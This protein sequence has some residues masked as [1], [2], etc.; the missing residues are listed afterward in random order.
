MFSPIRSRSARRRGREPP[1]EQL[2]GAQVEQGRGAAAVPM[3]R[4]SDAGAQRG[5][6]RLRNRPNA[7][8]A[9]LEEGEARFRYRP[10]E[11]E[12]R[13]PSEEASPRPIS[14]W[15]DVALGRRDRS[16]TA[17]TLA[18]CPSGRG[19]QLFALPSGPGGR[20]LRRLLHCGHSS[21]PLMALAQPRSA[22]GCLPSRAL[23]GSRGDGS[24]SRSI[25]RFLT[26]ELI[27]AVKPGGA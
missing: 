7:L 15:W 18:A 20:C 13:L 6:R 25:E 9:A 11:G 19:G 14:P 5:T 21:P 4:H 2:P 1:R 3:D 10:D 12:T 23:E 24:L 8:P 16:G 22:Q 17:A 27:L 26:P